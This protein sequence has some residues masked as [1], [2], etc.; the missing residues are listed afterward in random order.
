MHYRRIVCLLLGIWLGGGLL[1][2]WYGARGFNIVESIVA[3][4][5]P[6]FVAQTKALGPA[7]TRIAIRYILAEQN[8]WL[9]QSWENMQLVLG[10]IMFAYLL[11]GTMEGKVSLAVILVLMGLTLL[12]RLWISPELGLSGRILD[13]VPSDLKQQEHA[14]FWLLHNTYLGVEVLKFGCGLILGAVVFS[15]RRSV[16]PLNQLNMIDKPNHRHVNW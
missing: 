12:E 11:F 13:Y 1:M 14:R 3:K 4:A 2:A 6:A 8:R 5:N 7:G 9:F 16:D 10:A 15:G